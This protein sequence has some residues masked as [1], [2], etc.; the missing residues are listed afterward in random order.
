M[1]VNK[2][3]NVK[4]TMPIQALTFPKIPPRNI[5]IEMQTAA[6]PLK[7][8]GMK[9]PVVK[10][11]PH[12]QGGYGSKFVQTHPL[13]RASYFLDWMVE[14]MAVISGSPFSPFKASDIFG[15]RQSAVARR[16][17]CSKAA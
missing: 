13:Y 17:A 15:T 8:V 11:S 16:S 6:S 7:K 4:P 9:E 5:M 12:Q 2:D 1:T 3:K 14:V 10:S